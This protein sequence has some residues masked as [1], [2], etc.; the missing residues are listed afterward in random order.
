MASRPAGVTLVAVI[1]WIQG[2]FTLIGGIL[3]L[4]GA[5]MTGTMAGGYFTIAIISIILGIVTVAVG[6]GLLRGTNIARVLTTIVL[7]LS[8]ANAV[9][10]IIANPASVV[11]PLISAVLAVIG[12]ILLYTGRANDYFRR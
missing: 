8:L 6:V 7:I 10:S 9:Y 11:T 3:A 5:P 1:V 12:L 2:L 4:I